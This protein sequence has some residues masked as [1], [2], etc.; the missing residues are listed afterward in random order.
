LSFNFQKHIKRGDKEAFN[1]FFESFYPSV[2]VFAFKFV[3]QKD[4]AEDIAQDAFV[5]FWKASSR[6]NPVKSAKAFIYTTA[7]NACINY[8]RHKRFCDD[9]LS[10]Q[11]SY[12]D[13]SYELIIE[14]ETYSGLYRSIDSLSP[15]M[16]EIILLSLQGNRNNEIANKLDISINTVKTLKKNAYRD[17]KLKLSDQAILLFVFSQLFS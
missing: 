8:L 2:F 11:I 5:Q 17:L 15:R 14:E 4:I 1:S 3:R 10:C 7:R 12:N 16:K 6:T 13:L 9:A